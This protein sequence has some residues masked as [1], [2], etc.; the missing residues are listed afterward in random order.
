MKKTSLFIMAS[1]AAL[2]ASPALAGRGPAELPLG[3]NLVN[4]AYAGF[5]T[6]VANIAI[7][8]D[9]VD[10]SIHIEGRSVDIGVDQDVNVDQDVSVEVESRRSAE[11]TIDIGVGSNVNIDGYVMNSLKTNAIG[12]VADGT[13][14]LS[15]TATGITDQTARSTEVVTADTLSQT[16]ELGTLDTTEDFSKLK[17]YD[18]MNVA[19]TLDTDFSV[20]NVAYNTADIDG[21]I[22]VV[23]GYDGR[24]AGVDMQNVNLSTSAIGAA[25]LSVVHVQAGS[26]GVY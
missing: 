20:L 7:N 26:L 4:N 16:N 24:H 11:T 6:V 2:V 3:E 12:A 22:T 19:Q 21:S 18:T 15:G 9:D 14:E 13:Y 5:S 10:G 23:G 8:T 25:A 1:V 17:T